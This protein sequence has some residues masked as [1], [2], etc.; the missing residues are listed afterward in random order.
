MTLVQIWDSQINHPQ[1][2]TIRKWRHKQAPIRSPARDQR[3]AADN[4]QLCVVPVVVQGHL[5]FLVEEYVSSF[6]LKLKK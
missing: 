2:L 6:L 3:V 5:R 4:P 1:Q